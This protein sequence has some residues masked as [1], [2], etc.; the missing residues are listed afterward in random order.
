MLQGARKGFPGETLE[1]GFEGQIPVSPTEGGK[2]RAHGL[3]DTES[4]RSEL[5]AARPPETCSDKEYLKKGLHQEKL[6]A[7]SLHLFKQY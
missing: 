4:P 3:A 2:G 6:S 1:S 7:E 5:Q